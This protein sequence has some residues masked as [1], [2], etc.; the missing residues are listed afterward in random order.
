MSSKEGSTLQKVLVWGFIT[1]GLLL[2][3]RLGFIAFASFRRDEPQTVE[4]MKG[5]LEAAAKREREDWEKDWRASGAPPPPG[6]FDAA[7]KAA[8]GQ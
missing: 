1:L 5:I 2:I 7:W 3:L 4:E 6:G 8:R